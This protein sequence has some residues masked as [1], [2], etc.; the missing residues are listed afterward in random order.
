MPVYIVAKSVINER[1][2]HCNLYQFNGTC[3]HAE[4]YDADTDATDAT[5]TTDA[6][7]AMDIVDAPDAANATDPADK[8]FD[9]TLQ[10]LDNNY[11]S[12][13]SRVFIIHWIKGKH[14]EINS[15]VTL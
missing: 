9:K 7:N 12:M 4:G 6:T 10:D 5:D 11:Y 14:H 1:P 8:A 15:G 13:F 2:D 3:A